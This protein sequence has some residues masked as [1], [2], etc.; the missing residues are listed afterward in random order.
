MLGV[1]SL[2]LGFFSA[3]DALCNHTDCRVVEPQ[4]VAKLLEGVLMD[5][6]RFVDLLI[7]RLFVRYIS[8]QLGQVWA[9]REALPARDLLQCRL[10]GKQ[11]LQLLLQTPRFLKQHQE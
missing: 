6:N 9:S 4:E 8:E 3:V 1:G 10:V 5:A 11:G 2:F 7:S